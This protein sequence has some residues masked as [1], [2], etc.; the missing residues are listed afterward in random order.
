MKKR[1]QPGRTGGVVPDRGNGK[2][3]G[4][5][6]TVNKAASRTSKEAREAGAKSQHTAPTGPLAWERSYA[7]GAALKKTKT[8][9]F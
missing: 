5:E 6:V 2:C 9:K 4:P 3:K 1:E 7:A 8:K